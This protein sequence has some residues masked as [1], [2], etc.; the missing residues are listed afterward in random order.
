M[1]EE[2]RVES[3][4]E[5]DSRGKGRYGRV[6]PLKERRGRGPGMAAWNVG[7]EVMAL[8]ETKGRRH[9]ASAALG[10]LRGRIEARIRERPVAVVAAVLAAG[11]LVGRLLSSRRTWVVLAAPSLGPRRPPRS[12]GAGIPW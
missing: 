1:A 5:G 8:P 12:A 10:R 6:R 11:W 7:A 4:H 3:P 2:R 9:L